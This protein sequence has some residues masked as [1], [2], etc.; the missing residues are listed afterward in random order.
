MF[1]IE[2][3]KVEPR[4]D[5]E[6]LLKQVQGILRAHQ[7]T[8]E[9]SDIN[10][11]VQ[12][13][14]YAATGNLETIKVLSDNQV[15]VGLGDYDGRTPLHLAACNGETSVL[16]FLLKQKT[17]VINAVDRFGGT[18]YED[19]IRHKRKGAAAILEEAGGCRSGDPRLK[20]IVQQ[21]NLDRE[22][23]N[24]LVREPKISHLVKNSQESSALRITSGKLSKEISEQ[25]SK[26]DPVVQRMVWAIKGF[27]SRLKANGGAIPLDDKTF[28]KAAEHCLKLVGEVRE[29]VISCR[30]ALDAEMGS[31]KKIL[32]TTHHY[33]IYKV[34]SIY[35]VNLLSTYS[36]IFV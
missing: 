18:P 4:N 21:S 14:L 24:R 36:Y 15:D 29:T 28:I 23:H 5:D 25:R 6:C 33:H 27:D 35:H 26:V 8:L 2:I 9:G 10:Y 22:I 30:A 1:Q 20:Q 31:G 16:E 19:A 13:C 17:V 3:R 34:H 11:T 12:M 7:A 32:R